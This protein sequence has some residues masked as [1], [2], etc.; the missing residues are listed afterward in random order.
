MLQHK[1]HLWVRRTRERGETGDEPPYANFATETEKEWGKSGGCVRVYQNVCG[2]TETNRIEISSECLLM[3]GRLGRRHVN[4]RS[5]ILRVHPL[6]GRREMHADG[7][8]LPAERLT[9]GRQRGAV[10][11]LRRVD[12]RHAK[13]GALFAPRSAA[14]RV[15]ADSR[16]GRVGGAHRDLRVDAGRARFAAG[17]AVAV[18]K[19]V[20]DRALARVRTRRRDWGQAGQGVQGG[21]TVRR[22]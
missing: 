12:G 17:K 13:D 9:E 15:R 7:R 1:R 18:D 19:A 10:V 6:H 16:C 8:S 3:L 2:V 5:N 14:A 11:P 4:F 21:R 20:A 22:A